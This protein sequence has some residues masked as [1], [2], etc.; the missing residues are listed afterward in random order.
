VSPPLGASP[1]VAEILLDRYQEA[2][3]PRRAAA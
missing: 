3:P 2:R 1:E